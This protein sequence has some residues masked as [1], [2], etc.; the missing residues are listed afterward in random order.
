MT[1]GAPNGVLLGNFLLALDAFGT[2]FPNKMRTKTD[3][4]NG[5]WV[6]RVGQ[7]I[8]LGV[9]KGFF[10]RSATGG[11]G[12][13]SSNPNQPFDENIRYAVQTS[14]KDLALAGNLQML[15]QTVVDIQGALPGAVLDGGVGKAKKLAD[16]FAKGWIEKLEKAK[17]YIDNANKLRSTYKSWLGGGV[18]RAIDDYTLLF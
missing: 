17:S 13:L 8:D 9:E 16:I 2:A 5:R 6:I 10:N 4:W 12:W 7:A 11:L 1:Q 14:L 18:P 15:M 3:M